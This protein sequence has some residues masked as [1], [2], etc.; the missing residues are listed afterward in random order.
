MSLPGLV[1]LTSSSQ[2]ILDTVELTLTCAEVF[3]IQLLA[4]MLSLEQLSELEVGSQCLC[5]SLS[6]FVSL[7]VSVPVLE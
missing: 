3:N 1:T 5:P 6:P 2:L 4:C 7:S